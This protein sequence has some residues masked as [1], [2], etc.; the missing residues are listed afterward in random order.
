[1]IGESPVVEV[2][3]QSLFVRLNFVE[4]RSSNLFRQGQELAL[5]LGLIRQNDTEEDRR[6]STPVVPDGVAN[7]FH[8]PGELERNSLDPKSDLLP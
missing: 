7:A 5:L 1:L 6:I 2:R 3:E 8:D 4:N